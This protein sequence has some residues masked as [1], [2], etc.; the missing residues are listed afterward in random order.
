L[1]PLWLETYIVEHERFMLKG[2]VESQDIGKW[3]AK[4]LDYFLS[5]RAEAGLL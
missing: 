2:M 3:Y 1:L 5:L 4:V